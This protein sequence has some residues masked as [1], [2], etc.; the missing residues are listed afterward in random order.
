M[1]SRPSPRPNEAT[2]YVFLAGEGYVPAGILEYMPAQSQSRFRYGRR[3]IQRPNA[4]PIDPVQLPL[5]LKDFAVTPRKKEMFSA[6]RDAAPDR[7]GRK[8][9]AALARCDAENL[10]EFDILTA[11]HSPYRI[12]GLAFGA[13]PTSGPHNLAEWADGKELYA[14]TSEQL[15]QLAEI[16]KLVDETD[17]EAY[18]DLVN[19]FPQ[20]VFVHALTSL[21][22]A[23]GARPKA[24][25]E[26]EGELWIAKFPKSDDK[27]NEPLVEHAT[28]MLAAELGI[29]TSKTK[30]ISIGSVQVL[31]VKRFDRN[32]KNEPKHFI[33]A[34]TLMDTREDGDWGSYQQM[35]QDARRLGENAGQEIFKRMACNAICANTDDHPRN[36]AFF[37]ERNKV[38]I[39]PAYDVVPRQI[40]PASANL[41]LRCGTRGTERSLDNLISR[42]APFGLSS[43]DAEAVVRDMI[44]KAGVWRELFS[45]L[46]VSRKD[47]ELLAARFSGFKV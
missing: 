17:E 3:Y 7:W 5:T 33:S 13:T 45:D 18:D 12:G 23:G 40:L 29:N 15:E 42:P 19:Q 20:E 22:S 38:S 24:M 43:N 26:H 4:I 16:V 37:V 32:S 1:T 30:I 14:R 10:S 11:M 36:H 8:V 39:T 34:F 35:A 46:G 28:M 44:K 31:L 6:L 21:F 9:L 47:M 27:W 41:A 2:V 25:I